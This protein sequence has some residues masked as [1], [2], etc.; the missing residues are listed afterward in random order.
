MFYNLKISFPHKYIT[1]E[2]IESVS[3]PEVFYSFDFS[4]VSLLS[5]FLLSFCNS[6]NYRKSKAYDEAS[7][8]HFDK[9]I[10]KAFE[11]VL[12]RNNNSERIFNNSTRQ[13]HRIAFMGM[14]CVPKMKSTIIVYYVSLALENNLKNEISDIIRYIEN[15]LRTALGIR[16]KLKVTSISNATKAMIDNYFDGISCNRADSLIVPE[17][18]KLYDSTESFS[19]DTAKDIEA[20]SW[21]V[22]KLLV[23]AF[24]DQD[25]NCEAPLIVEPHPSD[26]PQSAEESEEGDSLS[27]F[28]SRI[29]R[30][31]VLFKHIINE[32]FK[33]QLTFA[34]SN[35]IMIEAAVDEINE[36]ASEI[37][38]DIVIEEADVGFKVIDD[39]K[40]M[41]NIE[42]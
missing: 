10:P 35:S 9:H 28:Y 40:E 37:F 20:S 26:E 11:L 23:E 14:L 24:E 13:A 42:V 25:V 22:T 2:M 18:E 38:G 36:A 41:F 16:S 8:I 21:E 3:I 17:Y 39:Y 19:L 4:D 5:K 7:A 15:K 27:A 34:R 33:E 30:Y 32:E 1:G 12:S 6:Y 29:G 31:A